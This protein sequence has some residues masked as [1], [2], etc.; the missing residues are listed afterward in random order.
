[1]ARKLIPILRD[2]K[3]KSLQSWRNR[4][5]RRGEAAERHRK[6]TDVL[7]DRN[8]QPDVAEVVDAVTRVWWLQ[9]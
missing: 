8:G 3:R 5:K 9:R 7:N 4:R 6:E 2:A 1:M